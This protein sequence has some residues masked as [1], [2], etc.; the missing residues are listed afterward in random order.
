[1]KKSLSQ[2]IAM[3]ALLGGAASVHAVNVDPDGHGQALLYPLYTV[4]NGNYTAFSVTNT[5][6]KFK[7]VKVRFLEGK[8]SVEVLDFNLYLSPQDVW[9]G[10]VVAD[11]DGETGAKLVSA[12]TSCISAFPDGF[13]EEGLAFLPY[14]FGEY[15][16][17]N[18]VRARVGHIEIIEMGDLDPTVE[19]EPGVTIGKA[20]KHVNGVPGS[21]AAVHNAWNTGGKWDVDSSVGVDPGTGGLYGTGYVIN[22]DSAWSASYDATA[23]ANMFGEEHLHTEPGLEAPNLGQALPLAVFKNGEMAAAD[24]GWDAVSAVLM[25]ESIQNDYVVGAGLNAQTS[26]VVTFPTKHPYVNPINKAPFSN[27]W[28]GDNSCDSVGLKYYDREENEKQGQVNQISPKPPAGKGFELCH[29]TNLVTISGS[30]VYGGSWV[31]Q[32]WNLGSQFTE[33]WLNIDL[34]NGVA[35]REIA[36]EDLEGEPVISKGLPAIGFSTVVIEND[37]YTAS[38]VLN[39]YA[40]SY[41]HKATT[42]H[43]IDPLVP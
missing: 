27:A 12:D 40:Q 42:S 9:T 38:G 28:N 2:A 32:D 41:Q 31:S 4:E 43:D 5:T 13:P 39:T 16:T 30:K 7:A 10:A 35:T 24:D 23:L 20:I 25:K 1:M 17:D 34:V 29:E 8:N 14:K 26:L 37:G 3:A 22:V 18:D 11:D 19:L 6:D 21:C 36:L 15:D 33:G